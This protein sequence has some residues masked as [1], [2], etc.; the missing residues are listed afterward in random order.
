MTASRRAFSPSSS[1][2]LSFIEAVYMPSSIAVRM[3]E[4]RLSTFLRERSA[5][6][7][8]WQA[9]AAASL[10]ALRYSSANCA[11]RSGASRRCF[12]PESTRSSTSALPMVARLVQTAA[13]LLRAPAQ[14]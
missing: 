7:R 14:P 10:N 8:S 3:F 5:F 9:P 12:S 2:I 11:S 4:I 1:A 13:P 6:C